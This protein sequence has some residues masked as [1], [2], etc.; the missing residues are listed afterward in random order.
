MAPATR[1]TVAS[2]L[3]DHFTLIDLRA[4]AHSP[5]H[6]LDNVCFHVKA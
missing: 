3:M 1:A 6:E 5:N 2:M 4:G